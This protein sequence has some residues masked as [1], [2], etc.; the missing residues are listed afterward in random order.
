MGSNHH[1]TAVAVGDRGVLIRGA[2]GS[3]KTTLALALMRWAIGA[4]RP[5]CLVADDQVFLNRT[6]DG[7][8]ATAPESIAGLVEVRGRGPQRVRHRSATLIQLVVDLVDPT[9]APR[10]GDDRTV[11][12]EGCNLPLLVLPMRNAEGAF[13]ALASWFGLPPFDHPHDREA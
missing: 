6:S 10:F 7:L 9:E 1:A 12:V 2:S 5:A 8:V 4:G 13:A 3:G 11:P